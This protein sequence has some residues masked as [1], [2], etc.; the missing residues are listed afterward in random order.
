MSGRIN[1]DKRKVS[2]PLIRE[3]NHSITQIKLLYRE[4]VEDAV[5]EYDARQIDVSNELEKLR[6]RI[7]QNDS[8]GWLIAHGVDQVVVAKFSKHL[9]DVPQ[10]HEQWDL[11]D[12]GTVAGVSTIDTVDDNRIFYA[13]GLYNAA[14]NDAKDVT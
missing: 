3:F 13:E 5:D 6:L 14:L 4:L 11:S 9:M 2:R 10:L 7:I 1:L 8:C 12:D